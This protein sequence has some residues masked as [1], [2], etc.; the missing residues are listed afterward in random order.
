MSIIATSVGGVHIS[1]YGLGPT[2]VLLHGNGHSHHEFAR[3]APALTAKFHLVAWDMPG[4]GASALADASLSIDQQADVLHEIFDVLKIDQALVVGAS[5]GAF[6]AVAFARRHSHRVRA[7]LLSEL[8]VRSR[9]WWIAAEPQIMQM[10]GTAQQP[11]EL[12]ARRLQ[13]PLDDT[14]L[15]RWNADRMA[16]GPAAMLAAM[17]AIRNHDITAHLG[18]LTIHAR[19]L[20]GQYGPA[21]ASHEALMQIMPNAQVEI[22]EN[23]G[24][25]ISI[26]RPDRFAA[27]IETIHQ[28]TR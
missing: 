1:H 14:L 12:V 27:A 20:F 16:A 24:H 23:A 17:S 10:F 18:A 25:F 9:D 4:H 2:V 11:R 26:D 5:I 7:L 28:E 21:L 6:V 22:V 19:F 8:Q 15:D 13:T 3:V